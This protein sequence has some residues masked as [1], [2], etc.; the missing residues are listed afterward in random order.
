MACHPS[1]QMSR[2]QFINEMKRTY[3]RC[4]TLF[5]LLFRC[6]FPRIC[7]NHCVDVCCVYVQEHTHHTHTHTYTHFIW[8]NL[9]N[10][11][12]TVNF[13]A[14]MTASNVQTAYKHQRKHWISLDKHI[15]YPQ[16]IRIVCLYFI[17]FTIVLSNSVNLYCIHMVKMYTWIWCHTPSFLYNDG[18]KLCF[19]IVLLKLTTC[20]FVRVKPFCMSFSVCICVV[21]FFLSFIHSIALSELFVA[22]LDKNYMRGIQSNKSLFMA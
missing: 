21:F 6:H 22:V 9:L 13:N 10:W 3:V 1:I 18:Y 15:T 11:I 5:S 8:Q 14:S 12:H 16:R 2:L 19:G 20:L 7:E 17:A 4:F